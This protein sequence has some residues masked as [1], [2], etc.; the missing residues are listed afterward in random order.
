M[1][2][3]N[4]TVDQMNKALEELNKDFEGNATFNRFEQKGRHIEFTLRVVSSKGKGA[5]ISYQGRRSVAGCWHVHG[6]FFEKGLAI[7]PEAVF[8]SRG[9]PEVRVD[10]NGGNWTDCNIGSMMY[11]QMFS[12]ACECGN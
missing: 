12:E 2:A 8:I 9:G 4:I 6:F 10:K 3:R 1:Q 11:P 7:A 5:K